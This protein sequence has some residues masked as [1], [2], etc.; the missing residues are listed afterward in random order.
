ME[1]RVH[2]PTRASLGPFTRPR[3]LDDGRRA[4]AIGSRPPPYGSITVVFEGAEPVLRLA[5]EVD[6]AAVDAFERSTALV[7]EAP[8]RCPFTVVDVSE[9]TFIGGD[10]LAFIVRQTE[11]S[12]GSTATRPVLRQ[13]PAPVQRI[14]DLT[15]L[16]GLFEVVLR[17][18]LPSIA[19][20]SR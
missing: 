8:A 2:N 12:S 14:L 17:A 11:A 3:G 13:A 16:G 1:D 18:P 20:A 4:L 9:V 7:Q 15:G 10:G 6:T 5:G 19:S